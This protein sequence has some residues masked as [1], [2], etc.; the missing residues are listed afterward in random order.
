M[1]TTKPEA[2]AREN[3]ADNLPPPDEIAAEIADD[4]R[5]ALQQI[6]EILGD[7]QESTA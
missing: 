3:I 2:K 7:L 6:E 4:L 1:S 5:S